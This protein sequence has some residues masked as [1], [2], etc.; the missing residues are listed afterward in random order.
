MSR[1]TR[2]RRSSDQHDLLEG[3]E[4]SSMPSAKQPSTSTSRY[5]D[6]PSN[7]AAANESNPPHRVH[8]SSLTPVSSSSVPPH[9]AYRTYKVRWFGLFQLTLLNIVVSWDWLTFAPVSTTASEYYRVRVSAINWLSTAFLFAFVAAS[10][11]TIYIL[12]HGGPK[13]AIQVASALIFIGN[14]LR[15]AGTRASGSVDG[16]RYGATFVGQVMIGLAQPFVLAAPTRYSDMW[17][18][19][20]GRIAATALA[21]LANPFGG[22]VSRDRVFSRTVNMLLIPL[23]SWASLSIHYGQKRLAIFQTW[24]CMLLSSYVYQSRH[25]RSSTYLY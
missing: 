15:Y 8:G 4:M 3:T 10:P 17:F 1:I 11:V 9:A 2:P 13:P 23:R 16:A 24:C 5:T 12:N 14:W 6:E 21:S 22:A 18:Q 19:E 20:K 25:S 7:Q